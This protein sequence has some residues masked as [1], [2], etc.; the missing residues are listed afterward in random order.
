MFDLGSRLSDFPIGSPE[1]LELMNLELSLEEAEALE[2]A[3]EES[4]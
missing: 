1:Y 3:E 2:E 4:W